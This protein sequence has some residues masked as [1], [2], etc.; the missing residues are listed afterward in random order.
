[1]HGPGECGS[2]R[3]RGALALDPN[4]VEALYNA[5]QFYLDK[6]PEL[7]AVLGQA[8]K[9]DSDNLYPYS[10]AGNNLLDRKIDL[11]R[12]E[13]YLCKYLTMEPEPKMPSLGAAH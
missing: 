1:M 3:A 13:R 4:H 2:L 6:L 12:A 8:E 10:R 7:D 11:A 9:D 5:M